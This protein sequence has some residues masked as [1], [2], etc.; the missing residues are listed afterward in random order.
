MTRCRWH[1]DKETGERFRVPGCWGGVHNP[2]G[3]YCPRPNRE[4]ED[5]DAEEDEIANLTK[6]VE[7]LERIVAE[8]KANANTTVTKAG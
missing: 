2:A 4:Q 3:C 1:T 7:E 5:Y 6:R 8:L